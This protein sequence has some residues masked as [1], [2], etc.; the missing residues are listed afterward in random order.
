MC[1]RRS[2]Q[3]ITPWD[4]QAEGGVDY[5]KLLS[6]LAAASSSLLPG[7]ALPALFIPTHPP[8]PY[9]AAIR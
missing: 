3:T 8:P 2:A 1:W 6:T 4:V 9:P 7:L 5:E